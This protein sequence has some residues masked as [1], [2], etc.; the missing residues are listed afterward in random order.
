MS[1][2]TI[3]IVDQVAVL[4][5]NNPST[6]NAM[7]IE[8]GTT[9]HKRLEEAE[10][11]AR[12]VLLT[13]EGRAFCSGA[14]LTGGGTLGPSAGTGEFDA[15]AS[16]EAHY[17]PLMMKLRGLS[18]SVRDR[19]AWRR[20]RHRLFRR[21]G[22]R[23]H[24]RR[25]DGVF[26]P[27]LPQHRPRSRWRLALSAGRRRRPAARHGSDAARRT[28]SRRDGL[29]LGHDQPPG[30]RKEKISRRASSSRRG[31]PKVRAR[32]SP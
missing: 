27:G 11:D 9:L 8:M 26:P 3:E 30:R 16:L 6:L 31:W 1:L 20:R 18:D 12:A 5:L 17:N 13:G 28:H 23:S 2:V 32:P 14:S 7:S 24:R 4:R 29:Q 21:A 22:G 19:G 10:R 25:P 15:G